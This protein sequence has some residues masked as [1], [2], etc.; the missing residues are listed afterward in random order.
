M[1]I[2]S[3]TEQLEQPNEMKLTKI[4]RNSNFNTVSSFTNASKNIESQFRKSKNEETKNVNQLI[5]FWSDQKQKNRRPIKRKNEY[6]RRVVNIYDG[7]KPV[8]GMAKKF[9]SQNR[10]LLDDSDW[11]HKANEV[12]QRNSTNDS[13]LDDENIEKS[14]ADIEESLIDETIRSDVSM[15]L[16]GDDVMEQDKLESEPE[17]NENIPS[18]R[19]TDQ[20]S[21][22]NKS[23]TTVSTIQEESLKAS[24]VDLGNEE[25]VKKNENIDSAHSVSDLRSLWEAISRK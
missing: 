1:G 15:T 20:E 4:G 7:S 5:S 12:H 21:L 25:K 22:S 13:I 19:E 24:S 23:M 6:S 17:D 10:G 14:V 11:I 16:S 2:E 18:Y 3:Q 8:Y 9:E